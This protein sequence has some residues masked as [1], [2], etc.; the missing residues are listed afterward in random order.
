MVKGLRNNT[1][2]TV[3]FKY[4]DV[5]Y[6]KKKT[7]GQLCCLPHDAALDLIAM[8]DGATLKLDNQKNR[9]KRVCV[10]HESNGDRWHCP[11]CALAWCYLHL[12]DM[13]AN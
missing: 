13:G 2:Q 6:L 8:A 9:W 11:V 10:Y 7:H 4:K 1:K 5:S 3:Q 12:H